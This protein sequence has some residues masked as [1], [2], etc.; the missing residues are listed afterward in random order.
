[1]RETQ[2][3]EQSVASS[4]ESSTFVQLEENFRMNAQLCNFVELIY[5]KKFQPMPSRR[6]IINLG[7]VISA[8][9]SS[10]SPPIVSPFLKGMAEV[11]ESGK[12]NQM[13]SP[14]ATLKASPLFLMKLVPTLD[15]FAPVET[16]ALLESKIVGRLIYE[17]AA[18]FVEETIF[19]V[20]PHRV[21][22]SLVTME[23]KTFDAP[24][25]SDSDK[26]GRIWVDTTERLQGKSPDGMTDDRI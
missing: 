13:Q 23:L 6:Q 3:D 7:Q 10:H 26:S 24:L 19:V 8:Y 20:T 11:M 12:S 16:H 1:M 4:P 9:L 17:L 21:Q 15:R 14:D 22:R 2:Q 5:R 25:R 18:I